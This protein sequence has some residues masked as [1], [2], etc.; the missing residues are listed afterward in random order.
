MTMSEKE[1]I[2]D[3][4]K[5]CFLG[6]NELD[7]NITPGSRVHD[8]FLIFNVCVEDRFGNERITRKL[9]YDKTTD[10]I[11]LMYFGDW[12]VTNERLFLLSIISNFIHPF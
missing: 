3:F 7:C 10:S 2:A 12:I 1:I 8:P 11:M 4:V 6:S 9:H 5:A